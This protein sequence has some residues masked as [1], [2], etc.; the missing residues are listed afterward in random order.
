M[1]I[2][3]KTG[4][5]R[6]GTKNKRLSLPHSN[7]QGLVTSFSRHG[8]NAP[9]RILRAIADMFDVDIVSEHEPEY[10]GYETEEEWFAAEE[11]WHEKHQV[12]FYNEVARFVR[13]ESH[14]IKSGTVGMIEAE[15]AKRLVTESPELLD[16]DK[17]RELIKAVKIIYDRDHLV[18]VTLSQQEIDFV[19]MV[20]THEDDLPQA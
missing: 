17:R 8:G 2:G 3:K 12:E 16:E 13:G 18:K 20:A 9:A 10:G 19:K 14:D 4:G 11:A 6:K 15:I 1:A 5:R 7:E